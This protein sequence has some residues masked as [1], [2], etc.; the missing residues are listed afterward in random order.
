MRK[1]DECGME[2]LGTLH[3]SEKTIP[4]LRDRWW[5]QTAKQEEGEISNSFLCNI[6]G[7]KTR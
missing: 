4:I 6:W 2:K 1:I 7:E 5:P 3:S